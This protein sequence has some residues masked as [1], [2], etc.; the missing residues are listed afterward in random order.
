MNEIA[1]KALDECRTIL[2]TSKTETF[3][4]LRM[5]TAERGVLLRAARLPDGTHYRERSFCWWSDADKNKII[6]AAKRASNWARGLG[7]AV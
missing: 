4:D 6:K 7:V 2:N 1:Q 5:T 3:Y